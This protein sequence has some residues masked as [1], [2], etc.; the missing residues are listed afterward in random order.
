MKPGGKAVGL[1]ATNT[2]TAPT[3]VFARRSLPRRIERR[4]P[5]WLMAVAEGWW[6]Q[7]DNWGACEVAG[8]QAAEHGTSLDEALAEMR[9]VSR[10]TLGD[11]PPFDD[12][13]AL[14]RAWSEATLGYLHQ[15]SCADPLTG[16]ATTTHLR[17][18]LTELYLRERRGSDQVSRSHA[19]VV[20]ELDDVS[21]GRPVLDQALTMTRLGEAHR[22]VFPASTVGRLGVHRVAA[23]VARDEMLGRRTN[24]VKQLA[25]ASSRIWIE[26][27]PASD[28]AA[29][30]LIDEL[31]RS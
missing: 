27:L 15:I 25:G 20:S 4:V 21:R 11:E 16:L 10:L 14:C 24:L 13:R 19:L 2:R 17:T 3:A 8:R 31:S 6:T 26:G 7:S 23:L 28:S 1:F 5:A 29:V 18:A 12:V 9:A 22:T 30:L